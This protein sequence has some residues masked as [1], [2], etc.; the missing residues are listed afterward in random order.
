[1]AAVFRLRSTVVTDAG[2]T[3]RFT[4]AFYKFLTDVDS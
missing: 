1:M 3:D 4:I 2:L